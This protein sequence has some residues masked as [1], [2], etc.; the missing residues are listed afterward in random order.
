MPFIQVTM[1]EG[2]TDEQKKALL[3]GIHEVVKATTG[4]ADD[5]INVWVVDVPRTQLSSRGTL[6]SER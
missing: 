1:A 6:L 5:A 4:A 2:R 3:A